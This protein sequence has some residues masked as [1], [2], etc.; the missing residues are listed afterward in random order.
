MWTDERPETQTAGSVE[1]AVGGRTDEESRMEHRSRD[2]RTLEIELEVLRRELEL[3]RAQSQSYVRTP[4]ARVEAEPRLVQSRLNMSAI[5]E[6][7]ATF[8]GTAGN[9]ETWQ[10]QLRLLKQTYRLDDEHTRILIGMR[11]KGKALEWLHSKPELMEITVETLLCEIKAMFDHRPSRIVLRKRFE[12]RLWKKGE[13]FSDYVHQKI[14]LGNRV[15]IGEEELV[16]YIID[17][18]P[19]RALRDQARLSGLNTKAALLEAFERIT[20]WD[21][22]YPATKNDEGKMQSRPKMDKSSESGK[23]ERK[24][25]SSSEKKRCFNCGLPDYLGKELPDKGKWSKMF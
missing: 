13:T 16:E 4:D 24:E 25:V 21:K 6:L 12:E 23:S 2:M 17:G 7:L 11:L 14:I 8:D 10:K 22:K 3:L 1:G 9:F 15:P 20:F 19:D 18:I 5:V